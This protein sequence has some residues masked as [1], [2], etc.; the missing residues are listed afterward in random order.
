MSVS[1]RNF[2]KASLGS[3]PRANL[4]HGGFQTQL[5]ASVLFWSSLQ[6]VWLCLRKS[7]PETNRNWSVPVE[8]V[9]SGTAG[10]PQHDSGLARFP[11]CFTDFIVLV[12][13]LPFELSR[14][15]CPQ[16]E[17]GGASSFFSSLACSLVLYITRAPVT[18]MG[19]GQTQWR[20]GSCWS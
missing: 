9:L 5:M 4:G 20:K 10:T 7:V 6:G 2:W 1:L 8:G 18:E 15:I 17:L 14:G 13:F 19:E 16:R 3:L 12:H 11:I